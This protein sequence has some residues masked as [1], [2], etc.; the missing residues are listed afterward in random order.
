MRQLSDLPTE[1]ELVLGEK[2]RRGALDLFCEHHRLTP[3][4][5]AL[6]EGVVFGDHGEAL[7]ARLGVTTQEVA[8]RLE[9]FAEAMSQT[10][11]EAA[12]DI[13]DEAHRRAREGTD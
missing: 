10:V 5:R 11:Y 2:A 3:P 8:Y 7:A 4:L 9:V 1:P 12:A 6:L 13:L